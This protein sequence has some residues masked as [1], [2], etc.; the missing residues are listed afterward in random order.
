MKEMFR[1]YVF[2]GVRKLGG[3]W[4]LRVQNVVARIEGTACPHPRY[5]T[6]SSLSRP[7][8]QPLPRDPLSRAKA[9]SH[10]SATLGRLQGRYGYRQSTIAERLNLKKAREVPAYLQDEAMRMDQ[11]LGVEVTPEILTSAILD[12][13]GHRRQGKASTRIERANS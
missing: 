1:T 9:K 4:L 8:A 10:A 3:N 7:C 13:L 6:I 2:A 12:Q 11:T 5:P